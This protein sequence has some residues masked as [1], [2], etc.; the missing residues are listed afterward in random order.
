MRGDETTRA[1]AGRSDPAAS[2]ARVKWRKAPSFPAASDRALQSTFA[3]LQL[4][5]AEEAGRS[6][7]ND[8]APAGDLGLA[9]AGLQGAAASKPR[10]DCRELADDSQPPARQAPAA[11]PDY[12]PHSAHPSRG[13]AQDDSARRQAPAQHALAAVPETC[14]V[15]LGRGCSE[16]HAGAGPSLGGE[17]YGSEATTD[18]DDD[19]GKDDA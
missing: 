13:L 4:R 12:G 16:D 10:S 19:D 2:L 1:A 3:S 11:K 6:N 14:A 8:P 5:S 9:L 17:G 7:G 15:T 18:T